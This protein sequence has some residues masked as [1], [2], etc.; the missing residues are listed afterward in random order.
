MCDT[1]PCWLCLRYRKTKLMLC[2]GSSSL[3]HSCP[4]ASSAVR[5]MFSLYL[6]SLPSTKED[7]DT[8]ASLL[9][10]YQL[11]T[12]AFSKAHHLPIVSV[13][14]CIV[15]WD[16]TWWLSHA[17]LRNWD[18]WCNTSQTVSLEARGSWE[19]RNTKMCCLFHSTS[20]GITFIIKLTK[21]SSHQHRSFSPLKL[22]IR[23]W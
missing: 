2:P 19:A 7:R 20:N 18:L 23:V 21:N 5:F 10:S 6:W 16:F 14:L 13:F 11:L 15:A 4:W 17:I 1:V 8:S 22:G 9:L 12:V 3:R